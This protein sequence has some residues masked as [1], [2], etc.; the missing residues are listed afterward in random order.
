MSYCRPLMCWW[1]VA[2]AI[3]TLTVPHRLAAWASLQVVLCDHLWYLHW[4]SKTCWRNGHARL[5]LPDHHAFHRVVDHHEEG[6]AACWVGLHRSGQVEV[7]TERHATAEHGRHDR[8][9]VIDVKDSHEPAA[10]LHGV[11]MKVGCIQDDCRVTEQAGRSCCYS[12]GGIRLHVDTSLN[13]SRC[14]TLHEV[15][16]PGSRSET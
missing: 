2:D 1:E 16:F 15:L 13:L 3:V 14:V 8:G 7:G 5:G 4:E 12:P 6:K 11:D 9:I 10:T